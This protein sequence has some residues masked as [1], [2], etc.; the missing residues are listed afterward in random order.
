M[1]EELMEAFKVFDTEGNGYVPVS[2]MRYY[3]R[4][5]GISMAED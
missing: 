5:Y 2:E 3:L 1:K 4:N